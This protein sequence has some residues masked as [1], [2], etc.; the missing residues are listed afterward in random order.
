MAEALAHPTPE[1]EVRSR[2]FALGEIPPPPAIAQELIR[3]AGND[4]ADIHELV[5]VV[6]KSPELTARILRW[7]NSAY[8]GQRNQIFSTRDGIIRVLGLSTAKSLLLAQA[9]AVSF[10]TRELSFFPLERFWYLAVATATLGQ[11]LAQQHF[12]HKV[13]PGI[14]YT[15]G[16]IHN[17]G[18]LAL[19]TA[20]PEELEQVFIEKHED[21]ISFRIYGKIGIDPCV[22]G[23][24][25][26]KRWG[27]PEDF[28]RV[29]RYLKDPD[30]E[31]QQWEMVRLIGLAAVV[32]EHH[33]DGKALSDI[34][35]ECRNEKLVDFTTL[36]SVVE[37]LNSRFDE[38][39][40]FSLLLV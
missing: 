31:G 22:A 33:L 39:K 2:L 7:A 35:P 11:D 34:P 40:N 27:L 3:L 24:W 4:Q 23:A 16:L 37:C 1:D 5:K 29:I 8:Y 20:F 21:P 10:A 17:I 9:L 30:Y 38:L 32:A 26:G 19:V 12:R 13:S 28:V 18:L 15:A 25:L 36:F 14:A 6:E